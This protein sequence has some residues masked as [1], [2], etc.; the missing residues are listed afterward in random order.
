METPR[1]FVGVGAMIFKD[2]K[3]LVGKRMNSGHANDEYC[4][5]GGHLEY[6]ESLEDCA[7]RETLEE[8]G[9]K[10]KNLRFN[11]VAN[12]LQYLPKHFVNISF[13]ADWESGEAKVMEP[14]KFESW[15]WY[16]IESIPEPLYVMSKFGIE[17]YKNGK[18]YY[19]SEK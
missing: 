19:D 2:G 13:I 3:V 16:D 9:I 14:D 17:S 1:P 11:F 18:N 10:I 12:Q 5:P 4:F 7:K 8:A 15:D 6:M